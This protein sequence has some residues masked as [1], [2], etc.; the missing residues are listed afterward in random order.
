[1][2][3]VCNRSFPAIGRS[4]AKGREKL[5]TFFFLLAPC[6]NLLPS[7][8]LGIYEA[9]M[10]TA[11]STY[12]NELNNG[13]LTTWIPLSTA[14][15]IVE[16]CNSALFCP[17]D[18]LS[19]GEFYAWDPN[20]QYITS[21]LPEAASLWWNQLNSNTATITSLGPFVCPSAYVAAYTE[22]VNQESYF[23][24]CCPR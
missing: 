21:C 19:F 10:A 14:Y 24:A 12:V 1:M 13:T 22:I 2:C 6:L 5:Y 17:T 3:R 15:P 23:T 4:F 11:I 9:V 8:F 16:G 20:H 7:R 18:I